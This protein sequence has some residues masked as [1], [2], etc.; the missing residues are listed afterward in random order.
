MSKDKDNETNFQREAGIQG[1]WFED[2]CEKALKYAGFTVV[3]RRERFDDAEI[4]VDL[5][6]TNR[7][8][9]SFYVDCK[10][11]LQGDRPGLIRT[12]TLK[13]GICELFM[14]NRCGW[15]PLVLMASHIPTEGSGKRWL[16]IARQDFPFLVINPLTDG[17]LLR[18]LA[19]ADEVRLRRILFP[20]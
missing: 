10:G 5:I 1:K 8:E 7:H 11:S 18:E 2:T 16:E 14:L 19:N 15:G 12:D 20:E 9:I 13:K 3:G 6:A 4:E 17:R